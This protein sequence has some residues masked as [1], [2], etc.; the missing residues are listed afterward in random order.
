MSSN[1]VRRNMS[2][3]WIAAAVALFMAAR[4]VPS[5]SAT[6]DTAIAAGAKQPAAIASATAGEAD[7]SAQR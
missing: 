5:L 6:H 7:D 2:V 4:T 1:K 3:V